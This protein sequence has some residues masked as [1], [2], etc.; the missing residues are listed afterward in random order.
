MKVKTLVSWAGHTF[1]VSPGDVMDLDD[2]VA[3]ARIA[4]G[5]AERVEVPAEPVKGR[6]PNADRSNAA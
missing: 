1:S 3:E 2:T 4:A 6:K 5:L